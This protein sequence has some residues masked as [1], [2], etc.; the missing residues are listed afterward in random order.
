MLWHVIEGMLWHVIEGTIW[1]V[2]EGTICRDAYGRSYD[3]T[4]IP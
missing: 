4:V 1:H 2:I 3:D